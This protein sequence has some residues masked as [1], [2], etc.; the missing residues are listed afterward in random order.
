MN[1]SYG[2]L[3]LNYNSAIAI[4]GND[5]VIES[6]SEVSKSLFNYQNVSFSDEFANSYNSNIINSPYLLINNISIDGFH[7]ND[8]AAM[9]IDGSCD[10][11]LTHIT[12]R[13]NTVANTGGSIYINH[14][15]Y[16]SSIIYNTF[17]S[18][19]ASIYGGS[20]HIDTMNNIV[21]ISN[22][23]FI[24]SVAS[25]GGGISIY[26]KNKNRRLYYNSKYKNDSNNQTQSTKRK[27]YRRYSKFVEKSSINTT[28][29]VNNNNDNCNDDSS[30]ISD[31]VCNGNYVHDA[32]PC[33]K[34]FA[35]FHH[36][37]LKRLSSFKSQFNTSSKL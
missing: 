13:N 4:D 29:N 32:I 7:S 3:E 14:N 11:T 30:I 31:I 8:G 10:L 25:Y 12:F 27:L 9:F 22:N 16:S 21:M 37:D 34:F 26:N 24:K 2:S 36:V 18:C 23:V 6:H 28:N 5:A 19:S 15:H 35:W 1:L 33:D 20:I 17:M